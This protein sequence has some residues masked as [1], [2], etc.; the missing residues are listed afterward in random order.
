MPR[1][2]E[3]RRDRG[4]LANILRGVTCRLTHQILRSLDAAGSSAASIAE[5]QPEADS[6]QYDD[7]PSVRRKA[8]RASGDAPAYAGGFMPVTSRS[9]S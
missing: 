2:R 3:W 5:E 4:A 8:T 7:L 6:L 1:P 9:G